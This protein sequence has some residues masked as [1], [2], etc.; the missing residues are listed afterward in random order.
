MKR[1]GMAILKEIL[2]SDYPATKAAIQKA[3]ENLPLTAREDELMRNCLWQMA[4]Y[5]LAPVPMI[6]IPKAK[7]RD[8]G[9]TNRPRRS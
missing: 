8:E 9:T 7:E 5:G 4:V 3:E 6:P 1:D 2:G